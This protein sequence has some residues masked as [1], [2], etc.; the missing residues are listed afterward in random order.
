MNMKRKYNGII[1]CLLLMLFEQGC[2]M[3]TRM[4]LRA[5]LIQ[6]VS[7]ECIENAFKS[8]SGVN[9]RKNT[10]SGDA[11][12]SYT[13]WRQEYG[14]VVFQARKDDG[15]IALDIGSFWLGGPWPI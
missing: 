5:N 7:D 15:P 3:G 11:I 1:F 10:T 8:K 13:F 12:S 2:D 9:Y 4:S 6:P 14:G